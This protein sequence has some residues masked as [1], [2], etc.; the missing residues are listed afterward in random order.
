MEN[1]F[2]EFA[3]DLADLKPE[4]QEK[5]KEIAHQLI[6]KKKLSKQVAI[7]EGIKQAELWFLNSEG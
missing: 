1:S 7:K 2:K 3:S 6:V 5:A 4:I